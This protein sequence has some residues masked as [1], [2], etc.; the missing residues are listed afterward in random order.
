MNAMQ[1]RSIYNIRYRLV[2]SSSGY[3]FNT[4][5]LKP[6]IVFCFQQCLEKLCLPV[7]TLEL[8]LLFW[9]F[10]N[11][12]IRITNSA[13]RHCKR[14]GSGLV[15]WWSEDEFIIFFSKCPNLQHFTTCLF[16]KEG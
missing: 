6:W 1:P 11:V 15:Y 16:T 2:C 3:I 5:A 4:L 10:V 13:K 7:T 8:L 9:A 14:Y 12:T